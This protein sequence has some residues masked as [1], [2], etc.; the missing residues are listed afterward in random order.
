MSKDNKYICEIICPKELSYELIETHKCVAN[1]SINDLFRNKCRIN[2]KE[3]NTENLRNKII[4]EILK[5]NLGKILEQISLNKAEFIYIEDYAVHQITTLDNQIGQHNLSNINFGECEKILREKYINNS[6]EE[7]IIYK[8]ENKVGSFNIPI[9]EYVLFNKNGSI[10]LNL[11][12]CDNI[13]VEY[14]IPVSINENEI[15]KN[16][17]LSDFYNNEVINIQQVIIWI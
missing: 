14:N 12:L 2:Y 17:P 8:I 9:I 11:S 3:E 4:E 16:D 15:Y 13:K 7:L 10:K 1:C 5:G 6:D